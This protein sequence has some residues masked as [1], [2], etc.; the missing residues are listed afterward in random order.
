M[1]KVKI[2][3]GSSIEELKEDRVAIGNFFRQLNDLYLDNGLYFQLVMCEDYDDAIELEG[4]QSKYDKEI[5]DSELA[6]FIF[7]KKVGTYTEHEFQIAY[8]QFRRELRPKILTVFKCADSS[9]EIISDVKFFAD[10][11][12]KEL[13]HYYKTYS[14]TDSLKLWLIM[15]IKSMG[16]DKSLVEYKSGKI[17]INGEAVATYQNAPAFYNHEVLAQKKKLLE[18]INAEFLRLRVEYLENPEDIDLY[19]KYGNTAKQKSDVEKEIEDIEQEIVN[20]LENIYAV[21]QKGKLSERQK[22]GYRLIEAGKYALA[23][24][25]L[26]RDEIFSDIEKNEKIAQVGKDILS[27]A[28]IAL[29]TNV[30][31]ILQRIEALK[32]N[33]VNSQSANEIQSLYEKACSIT[34]KY[35]LENKVIFECVTF[36]FRQKNYKLALEILM[37]SKERIERSSVWADKADLWLNMGNAYYSLSDKKQ[38]FEYFEKGLKIAETLLNF[39]ENEENLSRL[40]KKYYDL[41]VVYGADWVMD[42]CTEYAVKALEYFKKLTAINYEKY[43]GKLALSFVQYAWGIKDKSIALD[44]YKKAYELLEKIPESAGADENVKRNYISVVKN[45]IVR[46]TDL[47]KDFSPNSVYRKI[48]LN[49][50]DMVKE[51]ATLNPVSYDM[52]LAGYYQ[53]YAKLISDYS[54]T[55]NPEEYYLQAY[56]IYKRLK[57]TSNQ[58]SILFLTTLAT[59]RLA[60][61]YYTLNDKRAEEYFK[62]TIDGYVEMAK[63][64]EV[65]AIRNRADYYYDAG[66]ICKRYLKDLKSCVKYLKRSAALYESMPSRTEEDSK[67]LNYIYADFKSSELQKYLKENDSEEE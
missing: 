14:N 26:D 21:V 59:E 44:Y 48:F 46:L 15:Q 1:K 61:H 58:R 43:Y 57:L 22:L 18:D 41:S 27:G 3:I 11:L 54:V 35:D 13:Q 50:F 8:S 37:Q 34:Q 20:Q 45:Y 66:M 9:N 16:L 33:G 39:E 24:A 30:N 64:E 17:T 53:T 12:D 51:M 36:L 23:L 65:Y 2:F 55:E 28:K 19:I 63:M 42:K 60:K 40:A 49:A 4:K 52:T 25:V 47:Y 6:V 5:E 10:K 31:E 62:E 7:Y 56:R 67:W 32:I 38:F 29:Q